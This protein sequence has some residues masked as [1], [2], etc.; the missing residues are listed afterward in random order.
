MNLH[1]LGEEQE[2]AK[3]L[4]FAASRMGNTQTVAPPRMAGA[5]A[6]ANCFGPGGQAASQ[7]FR[8]SENGPDLRA[9]GEGISLR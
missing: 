2:K 3:D 9:A 4:A 5:E 8:H 1:R 6:D 7:E